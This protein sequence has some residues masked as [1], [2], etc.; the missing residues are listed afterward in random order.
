[1][2]RDVISHP[3]L[4]YVLFWS[5]VGVFHQPVSE[6]LFRLFGDLALSIISLYLSHSPY[7]YLSFSPF[8][9]LYLSHSLS[10][11]IS[12]FMSFSIC[13]SFSLFFILYLSVFVCLCFYLSLCRNISIFLCLPCFIYS[14][15]FSLRSSEFLACLLLSHKTQE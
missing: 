15:F 6:S 4:S 2:S 12:L 5:R 1:M 13:F 8:L 10:L 9:S 11:F 3:G 14:I 7:V